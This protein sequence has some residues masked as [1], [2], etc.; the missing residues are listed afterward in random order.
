MGVARYGRG[1]LLRELALVLVAAVF[2][3]PFYL[4]V[5]IALE[6]SAQTYKAPLRFPWPPQFGNFREAWSTAGQ[7]GLSHA[8]E[9]SLIITVS[10]VSGREIDF[11][12]GPHTARI[13][14]SSAVHAEASD[15][16]V[17]VDV[18]PHVR[19]PRRIFDRGCA[20]RCRA[21]RNTHATRLTRVCP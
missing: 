18:E 2:C 15:A 4:L 19:E 3:L 10:S 20:A 8:L 6:T 13:E 5:A 12:A 14:E 11:A 21:T 17:G 7:G 9:S 16:A 1:T